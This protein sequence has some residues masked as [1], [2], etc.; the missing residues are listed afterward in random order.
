MTRA[1]RLAGT[2]KTMSRRALSGLVVDR[3]GLVVPVR[4]DPDGLAG[5]T[6][7]GAEGLRWRR[8]S[9]GYY[10]PSE[11]D[12]IRVEQRI[13]EA[14]VLIVRFGAVT[15][16]AGLRWLGDPW[17]A[18]LE[19]DGLRPRPVPLV[20]GSDDIRPQPGIALSGE[21]LGRDEVIRVDGLPITDAVRSACFEARYAQG[22]REAVT[23]L[24]MAA[25]SDLASR[26]EIELFART[27]N[28]WTGVPQLRRALTLMDENSWSPRE[29][30]SRLVWLIDADL[31]QPLTN[32]P[33]FDRAGHHLGTPDL[34]DPEAGL[35]VEYDGVLHLEG[36]QR[37]R[38]RERD[39]TYRRHGLEV[40]TLMSGDLAD[41][42][43]VARRLHEVR[44]R[45]RFAGAS[46][47]DWTTDLPP[48]WT[49]TFSVEQRRALDED[50]RARLLRFRLRVG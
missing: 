16:W 29:V 13:V 23:W 48:W 49:P 43:R 8:T 37:R 26:S 46:T 4:R 14:G 24:D 36:R 7:A 39:E 6:K 12:R 22:F 47:R 19:P 2:I 17:S 11:V 35:V 42:D 10:V 18:G 45:C 20:I 40:V 30:S 15:G 21:R 44:E 3:P 38:D 50:Q 32:H 28:G 41:R 27:L 5:P 33:I 9:Q 31:P 1:H 25:Y 34:V